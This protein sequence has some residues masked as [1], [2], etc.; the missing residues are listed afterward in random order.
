MRSPQ[1]H[2]FLL[3]SGKPSIHEVAFAR[4]LITTL[5][6]SPGANDNRGIEDFSAKNCVVSKQVGDAHGFTN[7]HDGT[8]GLWPGHIGD[9]WVADKHGG[10]A[11]IKK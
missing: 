4:E 6:T 2:N 9:L 7:Y 1:A 8:I 11:L 10:N 5:P 3:Y